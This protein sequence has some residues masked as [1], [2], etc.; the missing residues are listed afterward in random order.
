MQLIPFYFVEGEVNAYGSKR[1][2]PETK[3][4]AKKK[5]RKYSTPVLRYDAGST[6]AA[7]L[8]RFFH[9]CVENDVYVSFSSTT[10]TFLRMVAVEAT[11]IILVILIKKKIQLCL[12]V[13]NAIPA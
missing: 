7:F 9:S 11:N 10:I 12:V 1:I 2:V 3:F 8:R 5:K 4:I 6:V 13:T